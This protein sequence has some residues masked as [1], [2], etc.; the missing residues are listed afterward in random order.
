MDSKISQEHGNSD[1]SIKRKNGDSAP[2]V[3]DEAM[4]KVKDDSEKVSA[5]DIK[6][7]T[8]SPILGVLTSKEP[9]LLPVPQSSTQTVVFFDLETT[10]LK[11]NCDITQISAIHD[12]EVYNTYVV[13]K[14]QIDPMASH[15]TGITCYDKVLYLHGEPVEAV[16][17][18]V[19]LENFLAWIEARSPVLIF[20][21]NAEFDYVR[22]FNALHSQGLI[23]KFS[24]H[25]EGF[26]DTLGLF[27][28]A[29]PNVI[30]YKQVTLAKKILKKNYSSHNS[31]EDVKILQELYLKSQ[32]CSF[33][34]HSCT[35]TSAYN[36]WLFKNPTK[37][38]KARP[39]PKKEKM[40]PAK[41]AKLK[42]L[43]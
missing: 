3:S 42:M 34:R 22:L 24:R 16:S 31:V 14:K 10:S 21:H 27:R 32:P 8:D 33:Y 43:L 28:A 13:P 41:R 29:F 4:K 12:K 30:N 6:S 1:S 11:P 7:K 25:I 19:A 23:E 17:Q 18:K 15:I 35:F 37:Q 2:R 40:P 36:K 5:T 9:S 39:A 20:A 38:K 26:V